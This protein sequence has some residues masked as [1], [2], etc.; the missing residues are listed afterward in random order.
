MNEEE[1]EFEKK[2][3]FQNWIKKKMEN[4]P[5]KRRFIAYSKLIV[6]EVKKYIKK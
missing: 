1:S 4:V 6:K 2:M 3:D 5:Y